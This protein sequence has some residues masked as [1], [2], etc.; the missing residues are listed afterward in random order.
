[1]NK[2]RTCLVE[3]DFKTELNVQHIQREKDCAQ[4]MKNPNL[5]LTLKFPV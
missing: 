4:T 2:I 1:M 3:N 5:K